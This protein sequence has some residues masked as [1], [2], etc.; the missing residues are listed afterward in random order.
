MLV[1]VKILM[2]DKLYSK[3]S[4]IFVLLFI[5]SFVTVLQVAYFQYMYYYIGEV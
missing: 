4:F 2:A 5:W 3:V 1:Q